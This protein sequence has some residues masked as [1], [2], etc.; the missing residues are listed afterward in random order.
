M[1]KSSW[2]SSSFNFNFKINSSEQI[3]NFEFWGNIV[4]VEVVVKIVNGDDIIWK[5]RV[6]IR[7]ENTEELARSERER[8]NLNFV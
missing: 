8:G 5:L 3:T 2:E 1:K 6:D 4:V 7:S